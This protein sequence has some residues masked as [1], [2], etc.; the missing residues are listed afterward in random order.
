MVSTP[1][2]P[3][4]FETAAAQGA[5]N[6][7]AA[8]AST[9]LNNSN[10]YTP[11]GSRTRERTGTYTGKDAQGNKYTVPEYTYTTTLSPTE[12]KKY[13]LS[14]NLQTGLLGAAGNQVNAISESTSKPMDLSGSPGLVSNVRKPTLSGNIG[15]D[16]PRRVESLG[17]T[18]RMQENIN[19]SGAPRRQGNIGMAGA[20]DRVGSVDLQS[21]YAP[22]DGFSQDRQRVEDALYSRI[23]P[24]LE[25]DR[26]ALETQLVNQ[27]FTRGTEAYNNALDSQGRKEND[28]RM[29][30]ILAGG[31]E[32]SRLLG[33]ARA[34]GEFANNY[35]LAGAQ[36]TNDARNAA[37]NEELA[38]KGFTNASR[39]AALNEQL[40]SKGFTNAARQQEFTNKAA[41]GAFQNQA[42]DAALN[43]AMT[44]STFRNASQQQN[45]QNRLQAGAFQND[46][47]ALA[48]QEAFA[49]R[50]QPINEWSA[51]LG[52]SQV[53][54][55]QFQPQF[56]QGINPS[57]VA[58]SVY[59]S[60]EAEA[61]NARAANSGLFG[62]LTAPFS[63]F[64]FSD[65]RM[66]EDY[67]RIGETDS[68]IPIH[69]WR[70]K[71]DDEIRVGPMAQDVAK[72]QPEAVGVHKPT[73]LLGIDYSKLH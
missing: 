30:A 31:Q 4:P 50:N 71:G 40:A 54:A 16:G 14:T 73:G 8:I 35:G 17:N 36:F 15:F 51:A 47:R 43:E 67:G 19:L 34:A 5:S 48:N 6:R 45:Y 12:Q 63:M 3:D 61:A 49:L 39:D 46:A 25:R 59:R 7:E 24:Q 28:A 69:K 65:K 57:P 27:G 11:F 1:S 64:S 42:R 22:A 37:L 56:R 52:A 53:N 26:A 10:E 72:K 62:L 9:L 60:Y 2:P 21:S 32:Q 58:D 23:N 20:P 70:Y 66:K 41:A 18:P 55:P 33:E 29:Q 38:R 44:R 13:D 68:G